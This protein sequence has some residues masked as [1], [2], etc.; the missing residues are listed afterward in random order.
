[1]PAHHAPRLRTVQPAATSPAFP[2]AVAQSSFV[3][4]PHGS[5][6]PSYAHRAPTV[7]SPAMRCCTTLLAGL[8]NESA[9][10]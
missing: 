10:V 4:C 7:V 6:L 1:M 2:H 3:V 9:Q 8:P 5:M